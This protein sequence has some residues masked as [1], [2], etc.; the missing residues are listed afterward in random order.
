MLPEATEQKLPQLRAPACAPGPQSGA[1]PHT[2]P[3]AQPPGACLPLPEV[4]RLRPPRCPRSA[5]PSPW[6]ALSPGLGTAGPP[7]SRRPAPRQSAE[8]HSQPP[9]RGRAHT[10]SAPAAT[11]LFPLLH[12][13]LSETTPPPRLVG[14]SYEHE[15]RKKSG[16]VLRRQLCRW[17]R[18]SG[19]QQSKSRVALGR[20][21]N[22]TRR[23]GVR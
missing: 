9:P 1:E 16:R 19:C 21:F 8:G 14:I 10:R 3:A 18:G 7:C 17:P 15:T 4:A 22:S 23:T 13:A 20:L 2:V 6:Q 11:A 12:P 5:S